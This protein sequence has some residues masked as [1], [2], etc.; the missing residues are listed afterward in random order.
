MP[1]GQIFLLG[2]TDADH[3]RPWLQHCHDG[4]KLRMEVV[5][6][7]LPIADSRGLL[8]ERFR[9]KCCHLKFMRGGIFLRKM[10]LGIHVSAR[11]RIE[12]AVAARLTG[13]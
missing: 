13:W 5:M 7:T 8:L 12:T 1:E 6:R 11:S 2:E 3:P 10:P 9:F 4:F